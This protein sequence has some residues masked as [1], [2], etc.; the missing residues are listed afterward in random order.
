MENK[1]VTRAFLPLTLIFIISNGL[2]ILFRST[3]AGWNFDVN[4]II[5]GNSI[6]F[7]ATGLSFYL[8]YRSLRS[9]NAHFI[10]RMVSSGMVAKLVICLA[11]VYVYISM[12]GK[13]VNKAAI[14]VCC[15][16]YILYTFTEVAILMKMSKQK[17]HV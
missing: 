13:S 12:A 9:K 17:N 8:Y 10:L 11:A 3:F 7:L 5:I 6:L 16:L 15:A 1:K 2:L 14:L 4:I